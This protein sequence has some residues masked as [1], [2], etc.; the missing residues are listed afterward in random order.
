MEKVKGTQITVEPVEVGKTTVYVRSNIKRIETEDF[1]GWEYDE[2]QIPVNNF[3]ANLQQE[4]EIL[5]IGQAQTSTTILELME[6]VLL[7]GV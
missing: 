4:S 7:G 2:Q 3:I 5:K 6:V 1:T